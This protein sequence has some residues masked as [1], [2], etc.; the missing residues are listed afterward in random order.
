L[1]EIITV[2]PTATLRWLIILSTERYNKITTFHHNHHHCRCCGFYGIRTKKNQFDTSQSGYFTSTD[3][4][5]CYN[6]L[7]LNARILHSL[8]SAICHVSLCG[9]L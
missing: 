3:R 9:V 5:R 2:H 8:I 6:A 1:R 4:M 7:A